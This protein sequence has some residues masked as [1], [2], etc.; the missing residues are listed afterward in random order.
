MGSQSFFTGIERQFGLRRVNVLGV[1]I[2]FAW[3]LSP[4]GGQASLRLLST[5]LLEIPVNATVGFHAFETH[6]NF[7]HIVSSELEDYHWPNYGPIFMTALQTARLNLNEPRDIFGLVKVPD[8]T[9]LGAMRSDAA[10]PSYD[11]YDVARASSPIYS[12]LLGNPIADVPQ[13]ANVSFLVESSYWEIRCEP[14]TGNYTL[15]MQNN[16][17]YD[18]RPGFQADAIGPSFNFNISGYARGKNQ[19][20][21]TFDY[22]TKLSRRVATSAPCSAALRVVESETSCK[23]GVCEVVRMRNSKRNASVLFDNC[24]SKPGSSIGP[25]HCL[26]WSFYQL[27]TFLPGSDLGPGRSGGVRNSELVEQWMANPRLLRVVQNRDNWY[28]VNLGTL[29]TDVFA[30]RLQMVFNTFW[31]SLLGV[32]DRVQNTT[33]RDNGDEV[34]YRPWNTTSATG[35]RYDGEQYVCNKT[36]A[37][38]TIVISGLLFLAASVAGVLGFITKAPDILGYVSTLARDNPYFRQHVPSHMDGMDAARAL[39]DVRVMVGDVHKTDDV[40]HV[41]FAST[42][43]G[44][45][46]VCSKRTYD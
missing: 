18:P 11:W 15:E 7:T 20:R 40:G 35:M 29:P 46:R 42:D 33:S 16:T 45:Q 1:A 14:F 44:P 31:E 9:S 37:A 17:G 32:A 38:I 39:R 43:V 19:T 23:T 12:S 8:I 24:E 2:V 6:D 22:Q 4:L 30:S 28:G 34:P 3:L 27:C 21:F 10:S 5:K 13:S 26:W 41:A 36:F 25:D